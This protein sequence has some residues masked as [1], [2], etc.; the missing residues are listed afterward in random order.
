MYWTAHALKRLNQ[1]IGAKDPECLIHNARRI[2]KRARRYINLTEGEANFY[3]SG[4]AVLVVDK[5]TG[6]IKT[7]VKMEKRREKH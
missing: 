7:V 1:R 5:I 4:G 3:I 6:A 2:S